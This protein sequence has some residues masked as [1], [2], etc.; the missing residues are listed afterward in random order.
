ME[1]ILRFMGNVFF[2]IANA[3]HEAKDIADSFFFDVLLEGNHLGGR[4]RTT[5]GT[6]DRDSA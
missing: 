2:R 4:A 3:I 1:R 6:H 5:P